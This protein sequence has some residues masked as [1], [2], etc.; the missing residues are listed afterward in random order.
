MQ[1]QISVIVPVYNTEPYLKPCL[2]S[3]LAQ[4]VP[5][6]EILLVDDG[7][8]DRSGAICD[9]YAEKDP[10][11]TVIHQANGGVASARNAGL[12]AARGE[13]LGFVDADDWVEP[14]MF[15]GLLELALRTG[16]DIVQCAVV[17]EADGEEPRRPAAEAERV[18][19]GGAPGFDRAA[20]NRYSNH[21]V[22]K[23]FRRSTVGPVRFS[24]QFPVGEDLLFNLEVLERADR[25]AF[26]TQNHYHYRQHA[27]SACHKVPSA[28]TLVSLRAVLC[29]AMERFGHLEEGERHFRARRWRNDLD[30]CSKIARFGLPE[31]DSVKEQVRN[32]LRADF[33]KVMGTDRLSAA[34]RG[35]LALAVWAWPL[36]QGLVSAKWGGAK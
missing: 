9:E 2:D 22:D 5:G 35:K 36:Y 31:Y 12:E 33:R 23:L 29:R 19:S 18:V 10:R 25:V 30:I 7:S 13:W 27:D 1:P 26:G 11:L 32:D 15:S 21:N 24:P 8:T 20:W 4:T 6:L 14:D 34:E 17:S 16:A 3:L 28:Q